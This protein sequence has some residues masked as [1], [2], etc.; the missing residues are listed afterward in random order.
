MILSIFSLFYFVYKIWNLI[1]EKLM[2]ALNIL[3]YN[4]FFLYFLVFFL[5][6]K[7][8]IMVVI[9]MHLLIIMIAINMHLLWLTVYYYII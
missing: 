5:N 6:K 2:D 1:G 7:L 9:N 8:I 3:V 4:L